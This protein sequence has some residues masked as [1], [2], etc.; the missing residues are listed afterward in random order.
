MRFPVHQTGPADI[1][2]KRRLRYLKTLRHMLR[3]AKKRKLLNLR[4]TSRPRISLVSPPNCWDLANFSVSD[5]SPA[6]AF[7]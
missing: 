1:T 3:S 2:D 5:A 6:I 4:L 7:T